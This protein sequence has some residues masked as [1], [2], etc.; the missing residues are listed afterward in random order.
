MGA[1]TLPTWRP[2]AAAAAVPGPGIRLGPDAVAWVDADFRGHAG[3]WRGFLEESPWRLAE[4]FRLDSGVVRTSAGT[5]ALTVHQGRT[6]AAFPCSLHTQYV[7]YPAAELSLVQDPAQR[8]LAR[9]GLRVMDVAFRAWS[10]DRTVQWSAGL[11]ST[12]LHAPEAAQAVEEATRLISRR[13][14]QHAVLVRCLNDLPGSIPPRV[15]LDADHHVFASRRV[16]FFDGREPGFLAKDTVRRDLK[17]L[18]KLDGYQVVGPD[19]FR[20]SDVPRILSLYRQLYVEKHSSL[21]P[22]YTRRFV[23]RALAEGWLEFR[24]LRNA[25]GVLDGVYGCFSQGDVTSTP[26]IGYDT[27]L[28]TGT[29]LYRHLVALL[30]SDV[31]ERGQLLNYSSG[32][33][34]FKRRRGGLPVVESNA[35][36]CSHLTPGRRAAYAVTLGLVERFGRRYLEENEV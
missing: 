2:E 11:L 5:F 20:P 25:T 4:N 6:G 17:S 22:R 7:A 13:F 21:N 30:L 34:E 8:R 18:R 31:A 15:F 10:L 1:S 24:G 19:G 14:P 9:I 29:G 35:L 23:E 28:P 12:N 33:G 32:A 26:F 16:Y 27:S 3:Y 36:Y